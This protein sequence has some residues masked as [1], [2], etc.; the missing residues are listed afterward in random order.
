MSPPKKRG[1]LLTPLRITDR[2]VEYR[3]GDL[4]QVETERLVAY[5]SAL[6]EISKFADEE[7]FWNLSMILSRI[8]VELLRRQS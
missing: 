3:I 2:T 4:I 1:A 6:R 8:D 7:S 5:Q